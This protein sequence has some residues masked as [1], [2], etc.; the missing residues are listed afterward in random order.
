MI[1]HIVLKTEFYIYC[2]TINIKS[3]LLDVKNL[4]DKICSLLFFFLIFSVNI[5][6]KC[7][8][9]LYI[10]FCL[11][12]LLPNTQARFE[13]GVKNKYFIFLK[14]YALDVADFLHKVRRS[15]SKDL[16]IFAN[17]S[18]WPRTR[19]KQYWVFSFQ[20][21]FFFV[22]LARLYSCSIKIPSWLLIFIKSSNLAS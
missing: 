1:F 13:L 14:T 9:V 11:D 19:A 2:D 12:P 10:C 21:F 3:V 18:C 16:L 6:H 20:H 17:N 4:D 15:Y 7:T 8:I 22:F 5:G